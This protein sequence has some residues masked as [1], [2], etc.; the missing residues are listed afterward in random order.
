MPP[1]RATWVITAQLHF[2]RDRK[3][4]DGPPFVGRVNSSGG[5]A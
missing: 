1:W 2:S 5:S 3:I 4:G